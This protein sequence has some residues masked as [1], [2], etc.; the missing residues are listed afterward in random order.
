MGED[1]PNWA[2]EFKDPKEEDRSI[3]GGHIK[4]ILAAI[5]A[6]ILG[7]LLAVQTMFKRKK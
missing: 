2:D 1:K 3:E 5:T 7:I 6:V 4:A